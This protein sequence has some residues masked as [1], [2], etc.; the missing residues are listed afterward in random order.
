MGIFSCSWPLL[1]SLN[2]L[3]FPTVRKRGLLCRK[4]DPRVVKTIRAR[5]AALLPWVR[6]T[7]VKVVHLVRDPRAMITSIARRPGTWGEALRNASYQC[8]RMEEDSRLEADLPPDRSL[9]ELSTGFREIS[10]C[11]QRPCP[12]KVI[13]LFVENPF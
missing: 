9:L 1:Q 7:E 10:Q 5:R 2:R 6:G 4:S 3:G 12:Y 13:S 8:R 11:P